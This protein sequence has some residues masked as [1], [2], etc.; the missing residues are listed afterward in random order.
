MEPHLE[1]ANSENNNLFINVDSFKMSKKN[2]LSNNK[3]L[4]NNKS[5]SN[6]KSK[7]TNIVINLKKKT[8]Y[9]AKED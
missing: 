6:N 2:S 1:Q 7:F 5:L 8:R 4:Y 3:S 9:I